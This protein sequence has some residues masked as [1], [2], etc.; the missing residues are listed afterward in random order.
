MKRSHITKTRIERENFIRSVV[1]RKDESTRQE[2]GVGTLDNDEPDNDDVPFT[3][4]RNFPPNRIYRHIRKNWL[5]YVIGGIFTMLLIFIGTSHAQIEGT[6]TDIKYINEKVDGNTR[7]IEKVSDDLNSVQSGIK[8][9]N[10]RFAMFIE[11]FR[12]TNNTDKG[13]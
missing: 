7:K 1:D 4:P 12:N 6:R 8:S 10:D 3:N 11:L 2:K 5:G 9:L 13:E